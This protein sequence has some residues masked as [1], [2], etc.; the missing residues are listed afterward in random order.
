MLG[1]L[2]LLATL[3]AVFFISR[4][5]SNPIIRIVERA[6]KVAGGD[7]TAVQGEHNFGG[8]LSTLFESFKEMVGS[9]VDNISKSERLAEEAKEQ[10]RMAESALQDAERMKNAADAK[11]ESL[12]QAAVQLDEVV[13]SVSSA[14]EELAA[15]IEQSNQGAE[16][17]KN[18]VAEV[19]T[20][21]EEMNA[22]VLEVA[23]SVVKASETADSAKHKAA[24]GAEIVSNVVRQMGVVQKSA[25]GIKD[26]MIM[27]GEKVTDIGSVMSVINDIA[28]QTNLLALN[29]AIEAARAGDAG[30]GFAVVA[31]EVRKLAEKTMNATTEVETAINGI[32]SGVRQNTANVEEAVR[33]IDSATSMANESGNS[34]EAI[35]GYSDT[36]SMQVQSIATASEQQSATS[37]E[38]N[39]SIA[40]I[41]Q[42]S[43][44]TA[45]AMQQSAN[46]INELAEQSHILKR[47]VVKM[48]DEG[49]G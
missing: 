37:E 12:Y 33:S 21:M 10:T 28:D 20:A 36:N 18:R 31:D 11:S 41:N 13:Q 43:I 34:L 9:L 17:Q 45:E 5:I 26:D 19:A 44:E 39:R 8:E 16:E 3:L 32:Q 30:R 4:Q 22:T 47:L 14:S 40:G 46:A 24:G 1:A 48:K 7:F 49:R 6:Q 27:L 15:Q 35:V 42:I 29:A 25:V 38:I 2:T 23:Q